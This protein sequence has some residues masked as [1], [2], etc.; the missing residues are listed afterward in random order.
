MKT[1]IFLCLA[2]FV[3]SCTNQSNET[4]DT[5]DTVETQETTPSTE[6]TPAPPPEEPQEVQP[7]IS[8]LLGYYV[9]D[10][11]AK[12]YDAS[13]NY[14]YENRI[15]ISIESMDNGQI[16]G[17]SIVAGNDRPFSGTYTEEPSGAYAVS[18]REPGDDRYDGTFEFTISKDGRTVEGT[19]TAY[20]QGLAV[21]KRMYDLTKRTFTYDPSLELPESVGWADLYNGEHPEEFMEE[22]ERVSG[23]VLSVNPSMQELTAKDVENL[24]Q[25][26]LEV[27]RNSIYARHGYS[28]RNRR[29]RYVF[30]RYVDWYIPV[31][32]DIRDQLTEVEQKNIDL[33]KRYEEH[34]EKYYD[35]YGR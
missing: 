35:V 17:R 27:I 31:S 16:S 6:T 12:E 20:D 5:T 4:T 14:T 11:R 9:G 21:P 33:L 34:A 26:D 18:V 2:L 28:F 15:N 24:Y 10:F 8:N 25:G 23:E 30:D 19:W 3:V 7:A 29:M 32:T 1:L 13:Q 22:F